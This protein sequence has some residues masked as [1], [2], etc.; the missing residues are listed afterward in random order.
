MIHAKLI[1]LAILALQNGHKL[2]DVSDFIDLL[3]R[4]NIDETKGIELK[5]AGLGKIE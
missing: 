4:I 1:D 5:F 3:S 2:E